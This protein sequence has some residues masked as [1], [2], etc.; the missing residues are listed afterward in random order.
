VPDN[1]PN[2]DLPEPLSDADVARLYHSSVQE[3]LA[4]VRENQDK[5]TGGHDEV[6][7]RFAAIVEDAAEAVAAKHG[8]GLKASGVDVRQTVRLLEITWRCKW[9]ALH[10]PLEEGFANAVA[11]R[12]RSLQ[13]GLYADT[14]TRSWH[15]AAI[16]HVAGACAPTAEALE[17]LTLEIFKSLDDTLE[18]DRPVLLRRVQDGFKEVLVKDMEMCLPA[19]YTCTLPGRSCE[20]PVITSLM[21]ASV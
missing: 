5:Y 9:T 2:S 4:R 14:R 18:A 11:K 3:A 7:R 10:G 13:A 6:L 15:Y 20:R 21:P 12:L 8:A 19:R 17:P 16:R 1:S